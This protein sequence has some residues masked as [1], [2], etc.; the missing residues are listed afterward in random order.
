MAR[1]RA[2]FPSPCSP[3][4]VSHA[5]IYSS[6]LTSSP[7]PFRFFTFLFVFPDHKRRKQ[8]ASKLAL[9]KVP[10]STEESAVLHEFMLGQSKPENVEEGGKSIKRVEMKH[11]VVSFAFSLP[12]TSALLSFAD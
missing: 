9:S 10:P 12:S 7:T 4:F 1:V 5:E 2:L 6:I 11:T 8:E 3:S